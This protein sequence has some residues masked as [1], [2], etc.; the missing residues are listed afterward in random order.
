MT[1]LP[2]SST[3]ILAIAVAACFALIPHDA[4]AYSLEGPKWPTAGGPIMQL[5]LGNAG[6]PLSDGNTSWNVAAAP[7]LGMWNQVL[8]G[9]QLGQVTSN[10]PVASGDG[11]NSMI[12]SS[13]VFGQSFGAYTLAVTYYRYSGSRMAEADILFNTAQQ[14]DSYRGAL[15]FGS[16][17]YAIADIQRVALHELGHVIGLGHPDQA[18]QKVDAVMNSVISSRCTLSSDDI[19]GGQALYGAPSGSPTPTPTPTPVPTPT[20]SPTPKPTPTPTPTPTPVPT[21]T[22]TPTPKPTPTPTP[23]PVPTP[24]PT[25]TPKPTPT[26]TPTPTPSGQ[27]AVSV[28]ASPTTAHSGGTATFTITASVVTTNPVTVSYAM[29]GGAILGR[30]YFLSGT[31]GHVTI[32]AGASSATITLTVLT[33]SGR[34]SAATMTLSSGSTYTV[35]SPQSAT[36]NVVL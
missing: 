34:G 14:W 29:S 36:V 17:G 9:I 21:P 16:N 15:R 28:T 5:E 33:A 26:P 8:G 2:H 10:V 23:T 11:I 30:N 18:G 22:P 27:P 20:P 3:P 12:Y 7:A 4:R 13:S 31:P 6:R 32:P 35:S 24:T 19:A 1:L 25:P